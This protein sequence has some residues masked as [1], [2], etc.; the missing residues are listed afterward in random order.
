M[1]CLFGIVMV[2]VEFVYIL[3]L[4]TIARNNILVNS[5]GGRYQWD[6]LDSMLYIRNDQIIST[7]SNVTIMKSFVNDVVLV[8]INLVFRRIHPYEL[9]LKFVN[10]LYRVQK[11]EFPE[12]ALKIDE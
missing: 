9:Y 5:A 7:T 3:H 12:I 1:F 11:L 10:N 8:F 2:F 4:M 6:P